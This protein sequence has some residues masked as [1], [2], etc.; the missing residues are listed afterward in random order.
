MSA[1]AAPRRG[2]TGLIGRQSL[3]REVADYLRGMIIRGDLREGEKIPFTRVAEALGVSLTPLREAVKVLAEERLV[4]LEP[5]RGAVVKPFTPAEATELFEVIAA[6]E[7]LA[8][9]LAAARMTDGEIAEL[10]SMHEAMEKRFAARQKNA[11]FT[12]NSQIHAK[13]VTC[14]RSEELALTHA[15]LMIRG[16]RGRYIAIVDPERWAEAMDEHRAVM[17]AFLR[18][19]ADAAARIW[20]T[21]LRRSGATLAE[22]LRNR[23]AA[24][25]G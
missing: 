24:P 11:Y 23:K 3:H 19:D 18:R 16:S 21:H 8:A 6:L 25:A 7:S 9:E 2:H 22:V 1:P 4:E 13:I 10:Q 20:Q 17:E 15:R 14:A 12:L 5:N